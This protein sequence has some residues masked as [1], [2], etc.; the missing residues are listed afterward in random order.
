MESQKKQAPMVVTKPKVA[1]P[2]DVLGNVQSRVGYYG[3]GLSKI[4]KLAYVG[5]GCFFI[6]A[7][8][9]FLSIKTESKNVYFAIDEQR[10]LIKL[11]P[12]S[13]PNLKDAAIS[14]WASRAL[15]DTFDFS[16]FNMKSHLNEATMEWFTDHGRQELLDS[17]AKTGNFDAV[18]KSKLIV[19][20]TVDN[21]PLVA[22]KGVA[23]FNNTYMWKLEVPATISYRTE[24]TV[25][26]NKVLFTV[27]IARRSLL[28]NKS[29]LGIERIVMEINGK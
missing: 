1:Q 14:D 12:L 18:S 17:L 20:L 8:L 16:Y 23:S 28:E 25:Y 6:S 10:T 9:V 26:S 22:K 29:G 13:E 2:A 4:Q 3:E 15:V 7:I 5:I 21:T 19:G 27:T 24:S 11:I